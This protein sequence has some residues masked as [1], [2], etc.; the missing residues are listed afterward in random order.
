VP[1][2]RIVVNAFTDPDI[3]KFGGSENRVNAT[4]CRFAAMLKAFGGEDL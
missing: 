1:H 3:V 4:S 2:L